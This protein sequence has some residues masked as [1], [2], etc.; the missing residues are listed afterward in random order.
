M[1]QRRKSRSRQCSGVVTLSRVRRGF[2]EG[3][4][5]FK[6]PRFVVFILQGQVAK[7]PLIKYDLT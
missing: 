7:V 3:L 1:E 2:Q 4:F 5:I 6:P